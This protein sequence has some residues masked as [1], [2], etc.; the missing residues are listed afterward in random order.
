MKKDKNDIG[1]EVPD[2]DTYA[3]MLHFSDILREQGIRSA[4]QS[5]QLP[6]GSRGLDAGCGIGNHTLWLAE[7][8]APAGHVTGLDFSPE[9]LV[10]ARATAEESRLSEQVSFQE[11]NVAQLPFDVDT[12]DWVWS[13]DTIYPGPSE[14]GC[15]GE[16]PIPLVRELARVVKPGGSVTIIFWSSLHLLPGYPLLEARLN[17]ASLGG[18][19]FAEGKRPNLHF[20]RALGW[21]RDADLKEPTAYTFVNDVHAPLDNSVRSALTSLLQ[22]H[23]GEPQSKVSREDWS[24]YQRLCQPE[25]LDFILSLP[26]YYAYFTYSLFHGKVVK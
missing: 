4:I 2:P 15:P 9:F 5:L 11:G 7:A 12:F 21:L 17:A 22:W 14:S 25:S 10:H 20:S 13:A 1:W 8:V 23:W 16:D 6:S 18:T 19:P 24:E 26:D 3:Q